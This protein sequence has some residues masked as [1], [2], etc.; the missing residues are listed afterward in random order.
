MKL[1]KKFNKMSN[2]EKRKMVAERLKIVRAEE[3]AL[4]K[5]SQMLVRDE[6]FTP[7]EVMGGLD[8]EKETN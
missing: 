3:S 2:E 8:Y 7:I 6:K 1:P 4:T 5:L